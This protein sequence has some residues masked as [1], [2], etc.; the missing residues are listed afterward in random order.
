[1]KEVIGVLERVVAE[2]RIQHIVFAGDEVLVPLVRDHLPKH[3]ADKVVDMLKL[4]VRTPEHDVL[5]KTLEAMRHQDARTDVEKVNRVLD[6]FRAGGLGV[7]GVRQTLAALR[8]GQV[9]ELLISA[10][11]EQIEADH[12]KP[13]REIL[14]KELGM[15]TEPDSDLRMVLS[16]AL[17]TRARQIGA[18]ITFIEDPSLLEHVGGVGALLRYRHAGVIQ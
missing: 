18:S 10:R 9:N 14:E 16:D 15:L 17:V 5:D 8:N 11:L 4:D 3:L 13:V 6:E 12:E 2:D 7:V 1:V